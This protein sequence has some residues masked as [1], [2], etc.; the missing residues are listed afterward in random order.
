[1]LWL[2]PACAVCAVST[3]ARRVVVELTGV[4]QWRY[5]G[6]QWIGSQQRMVPL[7]I[8]LSTSPPPL[9]VQSSIADCPRG[10]FVRGGGRTST[11]N[12]GVSTGGLLQLGAP[13]ASAANNA[14]RWGRQG[15]ASSGRAAA[16]PNGASSRGH[17]TMLGGVA[18]RERAGAM[19]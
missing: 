16:H 17:G 13:A 9:V 19:R 3:P 8:L 7:P 10:D 12:P 14:G 11:Q 1:M 18:H 15:A 4:R 2:A 6:T 5:T